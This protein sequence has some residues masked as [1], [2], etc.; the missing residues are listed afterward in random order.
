MLY[1]GSIPKI[2]N[3]N[4]FNQ[5]IVFFGLPILFLL[6]I[7]K[8]AFLI[9]INFHKNNNTNNKVVI[10][11]KIIILQF[12]LWFL[13]QLLLLLLSTQGM[14]INIQFLDLK[15][16]SLLS[17]ISI[18]HLVICFSFFSHNNNHTIK[19]MRFII[20]SIITIAIIFQFNFTM[21]KISLPSINNFFSL[22]V[23][24]FF[25]Y[26]LFFFSWKMFSENLFTV[27]NLIKK[28]WI[29]LFT[30]SALPNIIDKQLPVKKTYTKI[31]IIILT[32]QFE[33]HF[34]CQVIDSNANYN[35]KKILI[36]MY[37]KNLTYFLSAQLTIRITKTIQALKTLING[38]KMA[39]MQ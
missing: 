37:K 25:Y 19:I 33:Q 13:A 14:V 36:A 3:I 30:N 26:W 11:T 12:C 28:S 4:N 38:W 1:S 15:T 34:E 23:L 27:F 10:K 35:N 39:L 32:W 7:M 9:T 5:L 22:L 20:L 8:L 24:I 16:L 6:F 21:I 18:L 29:T 17:V 31:K 2:N